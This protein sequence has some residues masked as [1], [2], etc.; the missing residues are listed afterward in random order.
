MNTSNKK[1]SFQGKQSCFTLIELLVVIAIIAIIAAM[2]LPALQSAKETAMSIRCISNQKQAITSETMYGADNNQ[3]L[4]L[5]Y[6]SNSPAVYQSW[7]TML[8]WGDYL[9]IPNDIGTCP[10][11]YPYQGTADTQ[12]CYGAEYTIQVDSSCT[13]PDTKYGKYAVINTPS[14]VDGVVVS[15]LFRYQSQIEKPANRVF[16]AD[17]YVSTQNRRQYYLLRGWNWNPTVHP[18]E[19]I[20]MRHLKRANGAFWDGH[21]EG[22]NVSDAQDLQFSSGYVGKNGVYAG[23]M[24]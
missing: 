9:K 14:T 23:W 16:A 12:A 5:W 22:I 8:T 11:E 20:A 6:C 18:S 17:S 1:C 4:P 13:R 3:Y 10:S 7:M 24:Q 15:T 2:L 19:G 21:A